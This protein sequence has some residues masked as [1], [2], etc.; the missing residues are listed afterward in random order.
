MLLASSLGPVSRRSLLSGFAVPFLMQGN[1]PAPAAKNLR[2]SQMFL[3]DTWI[4]ETIRLERVWETAEVFPEPV[5]KPT[6]PWEGRQVVMFGS[7]FRLGDDWRMY[8]MTYN[9]PAP[10]LFCMATSSDGLHWERPNLGLYEFGGSKANNIAWAPAPGERHDGP[11]VCHDPSDPKEPFKMMYYG[12]R[13]KTEAEYVAFSRDGIAWRHH[14][15]PVLTTTGDRTNLLGTRDHRGKFV[16]YLRHKDMMRRYRARTVWRSESDDFLRWT[17]PRLILRP[18]LLEDPNTELYGMSGFLYS[19]MYLGMLER[20]YGNPDVIDIQLAWSHDGEAWHRPQKRQSFIGP[21]YPWNKG[22]TSCANTAP[23]LVGNQLWFYF[24]GRSSAHGREHPQSY[25]A[26]GLATIT[27][28]RFS[29]IRADYQEG[30]LI[31]KPMTWPGGDL[32]LNCTNTRYPAGHP[33]SG[34]GEISVEV[35]DSGN[36]PLPDFSGE[37]R[38]RF[39]FVSPRSRASD[40]RAVKWP[41]DLSLA[42][43]AGRSIRLVF[44]LRDARLYSFQAGG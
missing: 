43:L 23:I 10:P 17:E 3:D 15:E 12:W 2:K 30:Q 38:A 26:I 33:Y 7:V 40:L 8:Y 21:V 16:A 36:A 37:N 19:D 4:E 42:T 32:L 27:L 44:R 20:L 35:R 1:P 18:D 39:N 41:Q 5:L 6:A 25:G 11:T 34:G 22:W 13:N 9:P 28:D 14:P 24:G 29:A 31:T